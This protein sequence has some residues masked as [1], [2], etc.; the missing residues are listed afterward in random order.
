MSSDNRAR[1]QAFSNNVREKRMTRKV[2]PDTYGKP[3]A[4]SGP[5][6]YAFQNNAQGTQ[7]NVAAETKPLRDNLKAEESDDEKDIVDHTDFTTATSTGKAMPAKK[8]TSAKPADTAELKSAFAKCWT[9]VDSVNIPPKYYDTKSTFTPSTIKIAEVLFHMDDILNGNEE[10]RWI[11]PAYFSLP[12]RIYYAIICY[13]QIYRAKEQSGKLTPAEGSWLRAFFRRFKDVSLPIAGPLVPIFSNIVTVLPSDDQYSFVYPD[14]PTE[15]LYSTTAGATGTATIKGNYHLL[16]NVPAL[17]AMMKTFTQTKTIVFHKTSGNFDH[18]DDNEQFVP[19]RTTSAQRLAGIPFPAASLEA[20]PTNDTI[21]ALANPFLSRPFP[22]SIDRLKEIHSF[23]KRSELSEAPIFN[24]ATA[25]S[26]RNPADYTQ[27]VKEQDL[28]WFQPCIDMATIQ[29]RFFSDSVNLSQ[30]PT[31]AGEAALVECQLEV[32]NFP[33]L[34]STTT[35]P[36]GR[37]HFYPNYF[38]TLKSTFRSTTAELE[39]DQQYA[40][41][42]AITNTILTW[43]TPS[44][45]IGSIANNDRSGQYWTNTKYNYEQDHPQFVTSGIRTMIQT[46]FY[47]AKGKASA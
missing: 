8:V 24:E 42:Y 41:A 37:N 23:W 1:A 19:F 43:Q 5:P 7:D 2:Q 39:L 28:D 17:L 35:T 20:T 40:A 21:L 32:S 34:P 36:P 15:S 4:K 33:D 45:P 44:G 30:I 25:F 22:E 11:S 18:F 10:L 27:M 12:V 6:S 46:M 3:A 47:D 26:P 13:V 31:V 14:V 29:T 16:P 9:T 38:N